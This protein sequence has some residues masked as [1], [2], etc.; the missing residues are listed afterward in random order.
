MLDLPLDIYETYAY[1]V[2]F[3]FSQDGESTFK[4]SINYLARKLKCSR[5]KA[6]RVLK[7]LV[8]KNLAK[9]I[10]FINNGVKFCEYQAILPDTG[11]VCET[12]GGSV[13]GTPNNKDIENIDNK[14]T[15]ISKDIIGKESSLFDGKEGADCHEGKGEISNKHQ[16]KESGNSPAA[17]KEELMKRREQG[18][19]DGCYKYVGEFGTQMV[20]DFI[21]YWTEPNKSKS[22]MRFE[23][24]RTWDTHRRMLTWSR[25]NFNKYNRQEQPERQS[26]SANEALK[27]AGWI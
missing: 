19:R 25:N 8:D 13:R 12:P 1:A 23:L 27:R 11:S 6:I 24:E 17:S 22:A 2:I 14:E 18:F 16:T 21:L 9:K 4:G 10:E 5:S 3:G 26:I 20:E 7:A 15:I